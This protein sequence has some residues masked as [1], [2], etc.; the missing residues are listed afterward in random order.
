M[1]LWLWDVANYHGVT[2]DETTALECAEHWLRDGEVARVELAFVASSVQRLSFDHF[3]TGAGWIG[4][5]AD[6]TVTWT[7]LG[8]HPPVPRIPVPR[9][10][11]ELFSA[12]AGLLY[13][14]AA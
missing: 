12:P 11:P 2:N 9:L 14:Q 13:A 10:A 3:R 5:R 1:R 8:A 7:P 4:S 6:G